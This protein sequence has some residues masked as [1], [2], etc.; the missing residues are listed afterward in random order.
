MDPLT[1]LAVGPS[2]IRMVGGMFGGKS[3]E[4]ANK[5]ADVADSLKGIPSG[6][7]RTQ[8]AKAI[9]NL[10]PAE[11]AE[12]NKITVQLAEIERDRE[13][14]RLKADTDQFK[15]SQETIQKEMDTGDEYVK[16]TRPMMARISTYT[17]LGYMLLAEIVSRVAQLNGKTIS[18]AD[19]ALAG[20][21][22]GPAG[23]YMTMRTVD[24]FTKA[25]KS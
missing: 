22:L 5:V 7:A 15:T 6:L 14:N 4:V 20:T 12:L 9:A 13:A 17:G 23:F 21:L 24:A 1:L 16:H 2:L 8:M 25:G 11:Q 18:G 19:V 3:A 10:T